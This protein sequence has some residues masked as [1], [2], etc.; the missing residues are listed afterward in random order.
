MLTIDELIK[1][2][3]ENF[4]RCASMIA[5]IAE[6][7]DMKLTDGKPTQL[8]SLGPSDTSEILQLMQGV[9]FCMEQ[10]ESINS[11][12][13]ENY[14]NTAINQKFCLVDGNTTDAEKIELLKQLVDAAIMFLPNDVKGY[15]EAKKGR[16]LK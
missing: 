7:I 3:N 13:I 6:K 10:A 14:T 4:S 12:L 5:A 16:I 8:L 9:R 1:L 15:I 11:G 2:S